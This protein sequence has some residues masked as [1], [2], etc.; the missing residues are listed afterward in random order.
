MLSVVVFNSTDFQYVCLLTTVND[1]YGSVEF[2]VKVFQPPNT[3]LKSI[4][5][6]VMGWTAVNAALLSND[7]QVDHKMCGSAVQ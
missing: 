4:E 6:S 3:H 2:E 1:V 7:P 5:S